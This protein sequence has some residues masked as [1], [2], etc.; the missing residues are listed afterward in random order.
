RCRARRRRRE[1]DRPAGSSE[2]PGRASRPPRRHS[3][4]ARSADAADHQAATL[5]QPREPA[6][7]PGGWPDLS[8]LF[9][10]RRRQDKGASLPKKRPRFLGAEF[11]Q[12]PFRLETERLVSTPKLSGEELKGIG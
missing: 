3:P 4:C 1:G 12:S 8:R 9:F 7:F 2:P 10:F 11:R 5:L 6:G